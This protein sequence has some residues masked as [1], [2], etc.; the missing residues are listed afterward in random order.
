MSDLSKNPAPRIRRSAIDLS[1]NMMTTQGFG[2]LIPMPPIFCMPGDVWNLSVSA[3]LRAQPMVRPPLSRVKTRIYSFFVP[4]RILWDKWTRFIGG[5][6]KLPADPNPIMPMIINNNQDRVDIMTGIGSIWDYFGWPVN[7]QATDL[8]AGGILQQFPHLAYW[9]IWNYYFRVPAIQDELVP[10]FADTTPA[11]DWQWLPAYRNHIIDYFTGAL[12]FPQMGVSPALSI[13]GGSID[14]NLTNVQIG[15]AI[16]GDRYVGGVGAV[17]TGSGPKAYFGRANFNTPTPG[18]TQGG[19]GVQVTE[20]AD[21]WHAAQPLELV[22]ATTGDMNDL[23]IALQTQVFY[24]RSARGGP[25]FPEQMKAHFGVTVP[26]YRLMKPEFIGSSTFDV[27]FSEIPQTSESAGTA[28]GNLA[29]HGVAADSSRHGTYRCVEHGVI[30]QLSCI[31]AEALY[32]T[33]VPR[34][35]THR[36]Q[37]EFPFPEFAGIG[38]QEIFKG[39][40]F[41]ASGLGPDAFRSLF[42]YTGRFNECRFMSNTVHGQM[43]N[44]STQKEWV[45]ARDLDSTVALNSDFISTEHDSTSANGWMRPFAVTDPSVTPPFVAHYSRK[46]HGYRPI[47]F[48]AEPLGFGG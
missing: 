47:P 14:L 45:L 48:I 13:F 10:D 25:R 1:N 5:P 22:G 30:M 42:G 38:E 40:V 27:L 17:A 8:S 16:P 28:Q 32:Q 15:S 26:D 46:V 29:G 7:L 35:F 6:E 37:L 36:Q 21:L 44:V 9:A 2:Q 24:E 39:E 33:N 12:P 20:D 41:Y 31:T 4:Y 18:V 34:S 23:R 3:F 43:R 11:H 19:L